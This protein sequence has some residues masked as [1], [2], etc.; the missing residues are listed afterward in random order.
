[1]VDLSDYLL[2]DDEP[3]EDGEA[4]DLVALRACLKAL[5]D[6]I[7]STNVAVL[8]GASG[9]AAAAGGRVQASVKALTRFSEAFTILE[10]GAK[11]EVGG[12]PES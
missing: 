10:G 12:D 11:A 7:A 8:A 6:A 2:E 1:M 3:S 9:D 4:E 5:A